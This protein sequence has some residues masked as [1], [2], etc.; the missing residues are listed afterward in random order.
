MY[1]LAAPGFVIASARCLRSV[2]ARG[3]PSALPA[4]GSTRPRVQACPVSG[5]QWLG[6]GRP[7]PCS[8]G[9]PDSLLGVGGKADPPPAQRGEEQGDALQ[10]HPGVGTGPGDEKLGAPSCPSPAGLKLFALHSRAVLQPPCSVLGKSLP[11]AAGVHPDLAWGFGVGGQACRRVSLDLFFDSVV[12]VCL[13]AARLSPR[14]RLGL[15]S[16]PSKQT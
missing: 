12:L 3:L 11:R 4:A 1:S 2:P 15:A 13:H 8:S 9:A 5:G 7:C 6:R 16:S 10:D 14:H